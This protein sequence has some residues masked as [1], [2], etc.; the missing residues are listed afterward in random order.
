MKTNSKI[1]GDVSSE[2]TEHKD[3]KSSQEFLAKSPPQREAVDINTQRDRSAAR[4]DE[5]QQQIIREPLKNFFGSSSEQAAAAAN[6]S[7]TSVTSIITSSPQKFSTHSTSSGTIANL[8]DNPVSNTI[9]NTNISTPKMPDNIYIDE[10]QKL[11]LE[12]QQ[13][14]EEQGTVN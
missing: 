4:V 13:L 1:P 11:L 12:K 10:D 8:D 5:E 14:V 6:A 2:S 7:V 3:K 9:R